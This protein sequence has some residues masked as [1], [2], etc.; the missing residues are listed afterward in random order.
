MYFVGLHGQGTSVWPGARGA[1]TECRPLTYAALPASIACNTGVPTR[2]MT[3]IDTTTYAE[4]VTS[5]PNIGFVA[6]R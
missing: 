2:A 1:P 6:S 4:S 5:T 3:C